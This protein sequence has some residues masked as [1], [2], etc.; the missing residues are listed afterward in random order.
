MDLLTHQEAIRN[1]ALLLL[2]KLT[3]GHEEIQK[4][5]A[6]KDAFDTL[7]GIVADEGY[8][9]GGVLVQVPFVLLRHDKGHA[10]SCTGSCIFKEC[11]TIRAPS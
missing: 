3:A 11:L 2:I 8:A 4:I 9:A 10:C 7:F 1:E 5:V 6:Y